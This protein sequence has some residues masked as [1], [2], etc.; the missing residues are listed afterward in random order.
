M[1]WK[2]I[3]C[4]N[5]SFS[6]E[7]EKKILTNLNLELK[8]GLILL[9]GPNGCGKSTLLRLAAGVEMPDSGKILIDGTDLWEDEVKARNHLVYF[10][11]YPDLT[12]YATIKEILDL[13]CRL[14]GKPIKNGVEALRETGMQ[15]L[16]KRTVRELSNGQRR[17]A[18]FA[19]CL[20]GGAPV[21][22]LDEPLEGMD[23]LMR[24][25]ILSWLRERVN[26]QSTILLASHTLQPFLPLVNQAVTIRNGGAV[27]YRNLPP[28]R[29]QKR[30]LLEKLTGS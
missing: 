7:R 23:S 30:L 12:P 8:P 17:R 22:L 13:V 6:Y 24:K 28:D 16:M 26:D 3:L 1:E 9:L 29:Q 2:L 10:P 15:H 20:V 4:E 27:H 21:I 25:K 18:I 19:A 14:R 11:E 5:V